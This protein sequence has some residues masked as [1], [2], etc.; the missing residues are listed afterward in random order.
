MSKKCVITGGCGFVGSHIVE[1]LLKNT[2]WNIVVLDKLNY[3]SSGY[4]RLRDIEC[5]D[6]SR[7]K[8]FTP[9]LQEPLSD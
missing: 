3:A 4:D 9:D 6:E 1:H 2:D 8:I 5:F 7:V